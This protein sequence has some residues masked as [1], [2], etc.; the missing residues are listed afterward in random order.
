[1]KMKG[2]LNE[3]PT[4]IGS[5][6]AFNFAIQGVKRRRGYFPKGMRMKSALNERITLI[7][8]NEGSGYWI[9]YCNARDKETLL[10]A[11]DVLD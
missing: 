10:L 6:E 1:M 2:A 7:G 9:R 5:N 8:G 3:K 4:L 11:L